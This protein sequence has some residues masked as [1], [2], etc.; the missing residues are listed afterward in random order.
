MSA[1]LS[2]AVLALM[3]MPTMS[4]AQD[5]DAGEAAD[6]SRDYATALREWT[7]LADAGD[8]SAQFRLGVM[9]ANGLGVPPDIA[10]GTKWTQLISRWVI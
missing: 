2:G 10:T 8:A 1:F 7:P 6:G 9:Y 5:F 3:L 4:V